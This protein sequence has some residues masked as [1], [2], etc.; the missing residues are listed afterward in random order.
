[1]RAAPGAGTT[2]VRVAGLSV[3]PGYRRVRR[4]RPDS[5]SSTGARRTDLPWA[6]I[7]RTPRRAASARSRARAAR[8]RTGSGTA[9]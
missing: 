4:R 1:M 5:A 9:P 6:T 8:R 3:V 2:I 7:S